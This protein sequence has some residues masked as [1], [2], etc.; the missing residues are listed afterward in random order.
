MHG[1]FWDVPC[2]DFNYINIHTMVCSCF[3]CFDDLHAS[4]KSNWLFAKEH[5][6]FIEQKW[7]PIK[8]F[9]CWNIQLIAFLNSFIHKMPCIAIGKNVMS[10]N[11][12]HFGLTQ[13]FAK[14]ISSGLLTVKSSNAQRKIMCLLDRLLQFSD[15]YFDIFAGNFA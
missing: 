1:R 8:L 6:F 4:S 9:K 5:N 2:N 14:E 12:K 7:T 10:E 3:T 11:L 13:S 15:A